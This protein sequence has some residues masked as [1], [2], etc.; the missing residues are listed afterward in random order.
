LKGGVAKEIGAG[1]FRQDHLLGDFADGSILFE[2]GRTAV[3][4]KPLNS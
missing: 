2:G 4:S 3:G 1:E